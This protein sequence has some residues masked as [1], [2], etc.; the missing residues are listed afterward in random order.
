MKPLIKWTGGKSK[1]IKHIERFLPKKSELYVEPFFGGGAM[2][3]SLKP[4]KAIE[5][6]QSLSNKRV[7]KK[8]QEIKDVKQN[9]KNLRKSLRNLSKTSHIPKTHSK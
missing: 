8:D 1:E 9:L 5:R 3:F 7:E 6:V 2:F 4:K